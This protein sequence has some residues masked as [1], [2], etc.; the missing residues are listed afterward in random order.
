MNRLQQDDELPENFKALSHLV[1]EWSLSTE[2]ERN[3][4]RRSSSME[5]LRGF[6][7]AMLPQMAAIGEHLSAFSLDDLPAPERRLLNLALAFMEVAPAI[8]V[9]STPDVPAAIEAERLL[10]LTR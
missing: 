1:R 5:E 10:I 7:E 4:K 3:R 8:E 6:Y 2:Q 9:Y